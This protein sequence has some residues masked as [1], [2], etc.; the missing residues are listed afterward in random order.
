VAEQMWAH[1]TEC[2]LM[3]AVQSAYRKGQSTETALLKVINDIIDVADNRQVTLLGLLDMS[4]A[5]DTVGTTTT[6]NIAQFSV[7]AASFVPSSSSPVI[8]QQHSMMDSEMGPVWQNPAQQTLHAK[9]LTAAIAAIGKC[10][11]TCSS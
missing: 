11:C 10:W 5:F 1:L 9:K 6:S 3:P 7:T 2:D 4:A 8:G